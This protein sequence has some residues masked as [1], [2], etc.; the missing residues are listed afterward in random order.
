MRKEGAGGKRAGGNRYG[1]ITSV[2]AN[3]GTRSFWEYRTDISD[4]NQAKIKIPLRNFYFI[5]FFT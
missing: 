5:N 3:A 4:K 2:S 1:G